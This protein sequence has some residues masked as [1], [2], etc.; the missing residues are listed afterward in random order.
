MAVEKPYTIRATVVWSYIYNVIF[1][2]PPYLIGLFAIAI[3]PGLADP[4]MAIFEVGTKLLSP[5]LIGFVMAAIMA[6]IVS[7]ADSLLLQAGSIASRDIYQRFINPKATEKEMILYSRVLILIIAIIAAIVAIFRPPGVFKLVVFVTGMMMG[8]YLPVNVLGVYWK[9]ANVPGALSSMIVG[10][11]VAIIWEKF[12]LAGITG[13]HTCLAA[14]GLSMLTLIIVSL[15]TKPPSKKIQ[16]AV[17]IAGSHEPLS[18]AIEKLSGE[19]IVPAAK[20]I[21]EWAESRV[22]RAFAL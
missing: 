3:V 7:T 16:L 13:I 1:I 2:I 4:E 5:I 18:Q 17:E 10:T 19:E 8:C 15:C 9:R 14:V 22:K 21:S 20:C 6:A 12:G 11:V